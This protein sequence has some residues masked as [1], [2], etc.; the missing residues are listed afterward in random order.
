M[1]TKPFDTEALVL[2]LKEQGL[3]VVEEMAIKIEEVI[4]T[5]IEESVKLSESKLDDLAIP[6]IQV[7]KPLIDAQ[8]AKIDGK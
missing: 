5:W 3:P 2:M 4:L 8:I 7:L 6:I 1:M